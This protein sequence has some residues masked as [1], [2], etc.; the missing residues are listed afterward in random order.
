M[1]IWLTGL[2]GAGK[3]SI[4]K[5][6]Y[7]LLQAKRPNVVF[8]DGEVVR[9]IMG[10]NLGYTIADRR[11]GAMRISRLCRWL[12]SQGIDVV[13]AT[14]SFFDEVREWNREHIPQYFEVYIRVP[15][16]V[17]VARDP[18]GLYRQALAGE[19]ENMVGVDIELP[20]PANPDLITDNDV[21]VES[22]VKIATQIVNAIPWER[23]LYYEYS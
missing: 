21:P 20:P 3:T 1:V 11:V 13:C 18:N 22:F 15:F 12:D 8:L 17:L 7:R 6:V 10:K 16:D 5:E 9:D 19:I 14:I 23:R 2:S 4:G